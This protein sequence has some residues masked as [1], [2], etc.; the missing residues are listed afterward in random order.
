MPTS[1]SQLFADNDVVLYDVLAD[2]DELVN[3]AHPRYRARHRRAIL[4]LN[5]R[6][7]DALAD[8]GAAAAPPG[9]A[10]AWIAKT[11]PST[12]RAQHRLRRPS[13][14]S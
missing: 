8:E 14:G 5:A 13:L 4:A 3:L 9:V 12:E 1:W 10:Q 2:P 7:N 11:A 6:L